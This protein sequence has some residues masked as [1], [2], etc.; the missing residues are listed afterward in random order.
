[1]YINILREKR[2]KRVDRRDYNNGIALR[3]IKII[4][5]IGEDGGR[6]NGPIYRILSINLH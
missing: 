1:L 6:R 5:F 4:I 3:C 2:K